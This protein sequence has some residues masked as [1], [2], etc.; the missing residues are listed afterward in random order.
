MVIFVLVLDGSLK[1]YL[2]GAASFSHSRLSP[3]VS[4]LSIVSGKA[5]TLEM[6]ERKYVGLM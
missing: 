6:G 5:G 3:T 2:A 1:V 4:E